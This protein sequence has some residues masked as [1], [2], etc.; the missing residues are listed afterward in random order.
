[1]IPRSIH[2]REAEPLPGETSTCQKLSFFN[3]AESREK[4][5]LAEPRIWEISFKAKS[6]MDDDGEDALVL[7]SHRFCGRN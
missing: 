5:E 6:L 2:V 1:V 7:A 3:L 4:F